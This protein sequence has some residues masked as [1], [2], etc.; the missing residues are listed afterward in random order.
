MPRIRPPWFSR[1]ARYRYGNLGLAPDAFLAN[2]RS[3]RRSDLHVFEK[4]ADEPTSVHPVL[5]PESA[6]NKKSCCY[7]RE[8]QRA[9]MSSNK[10][11]DVGHHVL[12]VVTAHIIRG[13]LHLIRRAVGRARD[14]FPTRKT[15]G[16]LVKSG[17]RTV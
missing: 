6:A 13:G 1:T 17:C 11:S 15:L 10:R 8:E 4:F 5:V 12:D 2:H 16:L 7:G 3:L 9:W 14:G